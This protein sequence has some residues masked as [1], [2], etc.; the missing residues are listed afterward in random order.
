MGIHSQGQTFL[1]YR[2]PVSGTIEKPGRTQTGNAG[3]NYSYLHIHFPMMAVE[4]LRDNLTCSLTDE[5]IINGSNESKQSGI[6]STYHSALN[7]GHDIL[8]PLCLV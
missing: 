8:F 4:Y 6:L 2:Q 3:P 1:I 7:P 5:I